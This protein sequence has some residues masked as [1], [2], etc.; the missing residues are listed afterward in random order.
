MKKWYWFWYMCVCWLENGTRW[1]LV[2]FCYFLN[3][4]TLC[5]IFDL[6][7]N[8]NEIIIRTIIIQTEINL[9][10]VRK[11]AD[12]K[13]RKDAFVVEGDL[14]RIWRENKKQYIS[15]ITNANLLRRPALPVTV[16]SGT[17]CKICSRN[18]AY[19]GWYPHAPQYSTWTTTCLAICFW[20]I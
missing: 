2:R 18:A 20:S 16:A 11:I 3:T 13:F 6:F 5:S 12:V 14:K 7:S 10:K 8:L 17:R 15:K 9:L 4:T 19:R 1:T